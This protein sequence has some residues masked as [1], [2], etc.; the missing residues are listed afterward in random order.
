MKPSPQDYRPY[1]HYYPSKFQFYLL[2]RYKND[3]RTRLV[4]RQ[5]KERQIIA[6]NFSNLEQ[7][8]WFLHLIYQAYINQLSCSSLLSSSQGSGISQFHQ[9]SITFKRVSTHTKYWTRLFYHKGHSD[10][11][12]IPTYNTAKD[13][14]FGWYL[15]IKWN[16]LCN[17]KLKETNTTVHI[18]R[19]QQSEQKIM[20]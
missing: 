10:T 12:F 14:S 17:L 18:P 11:K 16:K 5:N 13:S 2:H 15:K 6:D 19:V 1:H 3:T 8:H 4:G 20:W 7:F 9:I